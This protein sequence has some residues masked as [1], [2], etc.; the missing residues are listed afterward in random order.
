MMNLNAPAM[1]MRAMTERDGLP[2]LASEPAWRARW[3]WWTDRP[4]KS[5]PAPA[6]RE[7]SAYEA[8]PELLGTGQREQE[9][10]RARDV[11]ALVEKQE[12]CGVVA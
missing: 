12:R 5:A 6:R 8:C 11:R 7:L 1:L 2:S 3:Q 10:R 9:S 4:R